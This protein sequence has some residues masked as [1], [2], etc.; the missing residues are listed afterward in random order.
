MARVNFCFGGNVSCVHHLTDHQVLRVQGKLVATRGS[1]VTGDDF[2]HNPHAGFK[3]P[4]DG[5]FVTVVPI[6]TIDF[7]ADVEDGSEVIGTKDVPV[8]GAD[9]GTSGRDRDQGGRNETERD[10]MHRDNSSEE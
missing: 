1:R 7:P 10:E 9:A 3:L 8:A 6:Q 4:L 2:T 5:D